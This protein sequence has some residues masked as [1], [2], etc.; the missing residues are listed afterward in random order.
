MSSVRLFCC[1]EVEVNYYRF[2]ICS[3][4]GI[5]YKKTKYSVREVCTSCSAKRRR[6]RERQWAYKKG[7]KCSD[8]GIAITNTANRCNKCKGN[9]CQR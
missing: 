1:P 7:R 5:R 4:C 2:D 8:C 3:D 6:D 9:I